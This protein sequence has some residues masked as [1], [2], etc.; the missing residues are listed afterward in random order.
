MITYLSPTQTFL[1]AI[2]VFTFQI[3]FS[4]IWLKY[5]QFGPTEWLW[6]CLTY[7]KSFKLKRN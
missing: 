6:R 7:R 5:F 3:I 1:T 4:K 2:V